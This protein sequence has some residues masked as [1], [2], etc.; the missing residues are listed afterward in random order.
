MHA[1]M[2]AFPFGGAENP[3]TLQRALGTGV[4]LPES[5]I[6]ETPDLPLRRP[7]PG[8]VSPPAPRVQLQVYQTSA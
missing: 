4:L 7:A 3:R 6:R 2:G 8:R 5:F 1:D